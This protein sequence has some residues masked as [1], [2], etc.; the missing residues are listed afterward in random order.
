LGESAAVVGRAMRKADGK[1]EWEG[2]VVSVQPRIRL[3]RSFD[4]R[5]H[6]YLGYVLRIR[7]IL[8]G[9]ARELVV[10]V[11]KATHQKHQF[12]IGDQVA[13]KGEHVLDD[14]LETADLYNVSDLRVLTRGP[15]QPA[16]G[17][18]LPAGDVLL[19]AE[20]LPLLQGWADAEGAGPQGHVLGGGGL[21]RRGRHCAAGAGRVR[22]RSTPWTRGVSAGGVC[23]PQA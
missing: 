14:R 8:D 4:Q 11:G 17:P 7:G 20:E 12:R 23:C 9:E 2:E 18:A 6:S 5:S 3:T 16:V 1:L 22:R 19:R 15:E 13:G 10:A 21:G